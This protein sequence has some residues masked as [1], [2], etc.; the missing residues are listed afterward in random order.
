MVTESTAIQLESAT[1][2]EINDCL[3]LFFSLKHTKKKLHGRCSWG[4]R[5]QQERYKQVHQQYRHFYLVA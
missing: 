2:G 5:I 4:H 1:L 3:M